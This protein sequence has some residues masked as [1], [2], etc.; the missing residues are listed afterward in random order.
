MWIKSIQDLLSYTFRSIDFVVYLHL[1]PVPVSSSFIWIYLMVLSFIL[2]SIRTFKCLTNWINIIL[3][4]RIFV[5]SSI[6]RIY[7]NP[8]NTFDSI[9]FNSIQSMMHFKHEKNYEKTAS[10]LTHCFNT[11][12]EMSVRILYL[13]DAKLFKSF[14][15]SFYFKNS[16]KWSILCKKKNVVYLDLYLFLFVIIL[17]FFSLHF[18]HWLKHFK[19]IC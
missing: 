18:F 16:C 10:L 9:Q 3:K 19:F 2:L 7:R 14:I 17:I 1:V 4:C 6:Y 5:F 12:A 15:R 8:F 13:N 11:S